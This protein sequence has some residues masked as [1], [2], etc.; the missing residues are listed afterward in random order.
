MRSLLPVVWPA[1]S[2]PRRVNQRGSIMVVKT[3]PTRRELIAMGGA[4]VLSTSFASGSTLGSELVQGLVFH[5]R[6]Q[7]GRRIPGDPGIAGVLVSNGHDVVATDRDGIW[8]LPLTPGDQV[9]IVKPPQW[10]TPRRPNGAPLFSHRYT[11]VAGEALDFPLTPIEEPARFEALLV[12][13]TQPQ[14][15]RELD[16]LRDS[17]L[18]AAANSRAAFAINHGDVVFDDL[19]LYPRYLNL[20]HMTGMPWHHCPGNHD[21]DRQARRADQCF[22]TW[23]DTFGPTHYAFQFAGATFILLNNVEPVFQGPDVTSH[24]YRGFIGARQLAFVGNLLAHVP[25]DH[26]VVVSMHIPLVGFDDP[27][28]PSGTTRDRHALLALLSG[29][30]NTL[31]LAG[32]T[33]TTEHHYLGASEGFGGPGLHHHHVLTAACGSWWSGPFDAMGLPVSDSRDGTPKGFHVLSVDGNTYSTRFIPVG[34]VGDARMRISIEGARDASDSTDSKRAQRERLFPVLAL[35]QLGEA[36]IVV[37]VFDGGPRTRVLCRVISA[38]DALR[39]DAHPPFTMLHRSVC[40]PF[41]VEAYCRHKNEL[42]PWVEPSVASHIWTAPL[43]RSLCAGS[44]R[45]LVTVDDEYGDRFSSNM[46]LEVVG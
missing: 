44:Y 17:I 16:Y 35:D 1:P 34:H 37:N 41:T 20:V 39:V 23:Q 45:L 27:S 46:L 33:H 9:F 18:I 11:G 30:P 13:D 6:S 2:E 15:S 10:A 7:S 19:S 38:G 42:K 14:T 21:M 8:R 25:R 26:L 40:D 36:H 24:A 22:A 43:P 5:D 28:D 32:H 29:R 4:A 31:T 12:T 3:R